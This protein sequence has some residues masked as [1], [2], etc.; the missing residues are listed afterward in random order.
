MY[1]TGFLPQ[2]SDL[3]IKVAALDMLL[4]TPCFICQAAGAAF[5]YQVQPF[6][7]GA[8]YTFLNHS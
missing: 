5:L 3:V 6:L 2:P 8:S 7:I 1:L 4:F